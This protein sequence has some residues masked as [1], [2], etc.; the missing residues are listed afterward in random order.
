LQSDMAGL[1]SRMQ[2]IA[3]SDGPWLTEDQLAQYATPSAAAINAVKLFLTINGVP[4][5][6]AT[7]SRYQDSVTVKSTV[8]TVA[9]L[10]STSFDNWQLSG[11]PIVPRTKAFSI[12]DTVAPFISDVYPLATFGQVQSISA[13]T[14]PAEA[15]NSETL[16]RRAAVPSSCSTSLVK[17]DCLRAYY[18]QGAYNATGG[19]GV[20]IAVIGMIDQYFSANDLQVFNYNFQSRATYYN[21]PVIL[22]NGATNNSSKPGLE[23]ML[24]TE[25][26]SSQTYPLT[27]QF[28]AEGNSQSTGDL[29]LLTFNDLLSTSFNSTTRPKVISISYASDES[30]FTAAAAQ[31]MCNAA[32]KLTALGTTIVVASA[33]RGVASR[34]GTC[35]PFSP[36]YP[37]G[38]PYILSVGATQSFDTEVMANSS[39]A[40]FSSSAGS[41]NIFSTPSYQSSVV[42]AYKSSIPSSAASMYN[43]SGRFFPDV[44]AQGSKYA[45]VLGGSLYAVSGTSASAPLFASILAL[46]NDQRRVAGKSPIGW[47]QP[48]IYANA[49][50]VGAFTDVT[51]GGSYNCNGTTN[52][53]P[54]AAGWDAPS[55]WGTPTWPKI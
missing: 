31:D 54:T 16:N 6:A 47:A 51:S 40:G 11:G 35:P 7:W 8:G 46:V 39:L 10:F 48:K 28:I 27:S 53:F 37:S 4:S 14:I 52:G 5:S 23:T 29:F 20:D 32:Q 42:N 50:S 33:D 49:T 3:S 22:R 2:S 15:V 13:G 38:C 43:S 55:G 41:S 36:S 25:I 21:M 45:V 12:P 18:G 26:V 1:T 17:P 30:Q 24:D 9:R 19:S 34:S 44:S